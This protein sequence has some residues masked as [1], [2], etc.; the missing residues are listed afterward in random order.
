MR[1]ATLLFLSCRGTII[2]AIQ[3]CLV[4][5]KCFEDHGIKLDRVELLSLSI[6]ISKGF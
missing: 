3:V 1:I 4:S 2:F 5:V 6:Q